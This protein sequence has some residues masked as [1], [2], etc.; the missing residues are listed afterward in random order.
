MIQPRR[1]EIFIEIK[2]RRIIKPR[3]G[4]ICNIVMLRKILNLAALG[5][6]VRLII[7]VF[8]ILNPYF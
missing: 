4:D 1:G 5:I 7:L 2:D 3:R 6:G 8:I